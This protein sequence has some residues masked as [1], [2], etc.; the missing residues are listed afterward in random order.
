MTNNPSQPES[1][2]TAPDAALNESSTTKSA[3]IAELYDDGLNDACHILKQL[4]YDL[5][6]MKQI[7]SDQVLEKA[8]NIRV[9]W[10]ISCYSLTVLFLLSLLGFFPWWTGGLFGIGLF[11][12]SLTYVDSF[13]PSQLGANSFSLLTAK[14][15]QLELELKKYITTIEGSLGFIHLLQ[16]LSYF[17]KNMEKH[18]FIR[19]CNASQQHKLMKH[20]T[21]YRE[22]QLYYQ[23]LIEALTANEKREAWIKAHPNPDDIQAEQTDK[24]EAA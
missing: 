4:D 16:P 17:N 15:E 5:L 23:Y 2:A 12:L 7:P 24:T 8:K 11:L 19:L 21:N 10:F 9:I 20:L 22:F 6:S 3:V 14:R 1:A 18:Y 13:L